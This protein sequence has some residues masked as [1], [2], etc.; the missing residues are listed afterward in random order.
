MSCLSLLLRRRNVP[1]SSLPV[2]ASKGW[3]PPRAP[4]TVPCRVGRC[5]GGALAGGGDWLCLRKAQASGVLASC[6]ARKATAQGR[7][8]L[9][10]QPAGSTAG[11]LL[12][13]PAAL[14]AAL[15][16][17]LPSSTSETKLAPSERPSCFSPPP[18]GVTPLT[19]VCR[20][21]SRPCFLSGAVCS[22]DRCGQ[23]QSLSPEAPSEQAEPVRTRDR[24]LSLCFK[25][26]SLA[27]L[28]A[29]LQVQL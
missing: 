19:S 5:S 18:P 10:R 20:G 4:Q 29:R 26:Q 28:P 9:L 25:A 21:H 3:H 23:A 8:T 6:P 2:T 15:L 22:L 16:G 27:Q 13:E 24:H 7:V 11:S 14:A 17:G 1:P 12:S